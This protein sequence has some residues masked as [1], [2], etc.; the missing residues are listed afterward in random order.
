MLVS[1]LHRAVGNELF[2][3]QAF[4]DWASAVADV[5]LYE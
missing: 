4:A 5:M 3:V 1:D 2:E